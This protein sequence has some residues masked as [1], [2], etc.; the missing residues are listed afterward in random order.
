MTLA[1]QVLEYRIKYTRGT[2]TPITLQFNT[3]YM[4]WY[5]KRWSG[6]ERRGVGQG[7]G[8]VALRVRVKTV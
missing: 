3:R 4:S 7:R 5:N 6:S 2:F 8:D 1:H